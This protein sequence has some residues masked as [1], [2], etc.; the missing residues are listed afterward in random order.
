MNMVVGGGGGWGGV[1][2]CH[3]YKSLENNVDELNMHEESCC[4]ASWYQ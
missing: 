1:L 3:A 2:C 4:Q